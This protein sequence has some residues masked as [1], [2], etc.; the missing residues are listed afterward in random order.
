MFSKTFFMGF[1]SVQAKLMIGHLVCTVEILLR[2]Q[3]TQL[4]IVCCF[5]GKFYVE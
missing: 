5:A 2:M 1:Q 3:F 4:L